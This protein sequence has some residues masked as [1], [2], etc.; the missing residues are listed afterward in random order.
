MLIRRGGAAIR[1]LPNVHPVL[2]FARQTRGRDSLGK[3]DDGILKYASTTVHR[4]A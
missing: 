1:L 3:E 4:V 2:F